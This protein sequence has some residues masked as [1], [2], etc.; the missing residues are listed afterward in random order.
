MTP[1][2]SRRSLVLALGALAAA[3]PLAG[4]GF[5]LRGPRPLAFS[6]IF[7]GIGAQTEL[8]AALRRRVRT[9]GT[10]EI[11]DDAAKAEVRLEILRNQPEREILTLTGAGKVREYELRHVITFRLIDR[12]GTERIRP[13][14][15]S[16]KREYTYDDSLVLAKEQEEALLYRDMQGDLVEQLMRRLAA[17]KP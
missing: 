9:S 1:S 13:T 3:G 2:R 8:G 5:K 7:I 4:C 14:S 6:S 17:V 12:A 16:A 15:I 11:V 10:T